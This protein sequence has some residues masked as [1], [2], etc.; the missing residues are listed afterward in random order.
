[1]RVLLINPWQP[2]TFPPPSIGY[3]QATLKAQGIDV[4]AMDLNGALSTHFDFDIVGVTFHSFSVRYA[5]IIREKFKCRLICGGHHPSALPEQMLKIGYNQVVVGE[6]ESALM[7]VVRGKR[8]QIIHSDRIDINGIPFPDYTGLSYGG[9]LGLPVIS[10]R[11]C[12]FSCSFCASSDF[13]KSYKMRSSENVTTEVNSLPVRKFMFEDDNFTANKR[14]VKEICDDIK[15]K[16]YSWQ[17]A[18]RAED[19][20]EDLC[21]DLHEAGCHTV[22]LGIESFSQ[23]S[24]DRCNKKTTVEKMVTGIKTAENIG[25]NTRCQFIV[26]IPDDT[27]EDIIETVRVMRRNSIH[28]GANIIWLL[29]NTEAYKRAKQ[30]GFSDEVYLQSGAPFYEYEHPLKELRQWADMI[31]AA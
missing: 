14:R 5:K 8:E 15:G 7:E 18:S 2:E 24:L 20:T 12:P 21:K 6:G 16:G 9:E 30:R 10:S 25:L 22:W 29:P 23:R 13:W 27:Q 3:L 28:G 1:M 19:L 4:S 26:G 17:C 31:N 11:G